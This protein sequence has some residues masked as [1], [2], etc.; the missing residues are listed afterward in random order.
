MTTATSAHHSAHAAQRPNAG[1]SAAALARTR[2]KVAVVPL[3]SA[4]RVIW[5][6]VALL[7]MLST[8]GVMAGLWWVNLPP[9]PPQMLEMRIG[10]ETLVFPSNFK[11]PRTADMGREVGMTRLRVTWPELNAA[12]AGD[13]AEVHITIG[14]ASASTDPKAQFNT[15]ARFLTQGAWSNPGGLMV[16]N[17]KK[18]SPFEQ[19]ELFM[20]M[21]D[22]AAFFAR[23]TADIGA[24][25]LDEGCRAV[26]KHGGFD[27]A[28]RFPRE[29][30][31]DWQALADGV[32]RLV[33]GFRR[34]E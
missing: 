21:P 22:G 28:L 11:G 34:S 9:P 18:G 30:L 27:I 10:T 5:V 24:T 6:I 23:C 25:K 29:A 8:G 13:K 3:P 4:D 19:E 20:S 16:R 15:L 1:H 14:P 7:T 17:F 31:G 33:D 26:L 2:N 32:R 12:I